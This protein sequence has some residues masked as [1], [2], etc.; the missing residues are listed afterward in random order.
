MTMAPLLRVFA[1]T[2]LCGQSAC[3]PAADAEAQ[4]RRLLEMTLPDAGAARF[5]NVRLLDATG[6]EGGKARVICGEVNA[7]NRLGAYDGYRRFIAV[8]SEGF[9]AADPMAGPGASIDAIGLQAG[10]DSLWPACEGKSLV[11]PKLTA[12]GCDPE[13]AKSVGLTCVN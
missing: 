12:G 5:Q 4:A 13:K 10:F 3:N 2:A 9:A 7:K 8:P 11:P 6:P 1:L